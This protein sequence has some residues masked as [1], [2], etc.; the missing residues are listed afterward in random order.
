MPL[1]YLERVGVPPDGGAVHRAEH[2]T[3][4]VGG[5]AGQAE[6]GQPGE[7]QAGLPVQWKTDLNKASN[8][9]IVAHL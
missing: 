7:Q 4:G 5:E 6:Q 2:E 1:Y 8:W 9:Q 3:A